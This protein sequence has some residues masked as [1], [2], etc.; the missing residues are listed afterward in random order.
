MGFKNPGTS[1]ELLDLMLS[2]EDQRVADLLLRE[3]PDF[4]RPIGFHYAVTSR[5]PQPPIP[6][7]PVRAEAA[8]KH[9]D[10]IVDA[11]RDVLLGG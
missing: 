11:V 2:E 1:D 4:A 7:R 3:S 6:E 5:Y 8:V 9:R 10:R